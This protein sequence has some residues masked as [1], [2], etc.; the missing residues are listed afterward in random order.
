MNEKIA[1]LVYAT[2]TLCEMLRD[3]HDFLDFNEE[4]KDYVEDVETC[5]EE[6]SETDI[7]TEDN[8]E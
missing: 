8:E 5:L 7:K 3:N 4:L 6:V 2:R 1:E